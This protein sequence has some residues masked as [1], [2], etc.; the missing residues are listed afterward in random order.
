[1]LPRQ[2][3]TRTVSKQA[4]L[5][6]QS[7]DP[8]CRDPPADGAHGSTPTIL[9]SEKSEYHSIRVFNDGR[10][11]GVDV[12]TSRNSRIDFQ[13]DRMASSMRQGL[14]PQEKKLPKLET[15]Q[16]EDIGTSLN[17][18]EETEDLRNCPILDLIPFFVR[19]RI[20]TK[21]GYK[22]LELP[23]SFFLHPCWD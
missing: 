3:Q 22:G 13:S 14:S 4:S 18:L 5:H 21:S 10:E 16:V 6:S 20:C 1:M 23:F 7:P 17:S 8:P 15:A 12:A 19:Q 11:V 9:P 2:A